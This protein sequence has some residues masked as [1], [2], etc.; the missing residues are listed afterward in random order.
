[1]AK[2]VWGLLLAVT[3]TASGVQPS[4]VAISSQNWVAE[5]IKH[6]KIEGSLNGD[7]PFVVLLPDKE[8]WSG[9]LIHH[10]G[11]SLEG[12]LTDTVI[13]S[14]VEKGVA[15][16]RDTAGWTYATSESPTSKNC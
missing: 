11:H 2:F 14:V 9:R 15:P 12:Q 16:L 13:A 1:M 6:L 7:T 8:V 5:P 10:L 3:A 4:T